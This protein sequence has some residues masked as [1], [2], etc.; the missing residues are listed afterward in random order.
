MRSKVAPALRSCAQLGERVGVAS[1]ARGIAGERGIAREVAARRAPA[2]RPSCRSTATLARAAGERREREAAGVAE[3]VEHAPARAHASRTSRAVVALVEIEAGLL[4]AEHVD[5]IGEPVLEDRRRRAAACRATTPAARR[6]A[7]RACALRRPSAR[8]T[9]RHAGS[10]DER[11]DDRRAMRSAPADRSCTHD[12]VAVAVG[13]DAGQAVGFA[14]DQPAAVCVGVEHRRARAPRRAATR[15]AKNAASI[16]LAGSNVHTRARICDVGRIRGARERM[17]RRRR[18]RRRSR[19]AQARRRRARSR[20][21]RSTGGAAHAATCSRPGLEDDRGGAAAG[22]AC[23]QPSGDAEQAADA[24]VTAPASAPSAS[25]RTPDR[26][27]LRP[28]NSDSIA[29]T[30]NSA[31]AVTPIATASAR[32]RRANTNGASGSSAPAANDRNELAAAPTG[33]PSSSGLRP[34]SSRA[35]VSSACSGSAT[36]CLA[37]LRRPRAAASPSPR[38]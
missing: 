23:G 18:A 3:R 10:A 38:R 16:A 12:D 22:C 33:E 15:R 17:R 4:A 1:I 34:S 28:V 29:P 9:Q 21:R 19:P 20:R 13:D 6:Q 27:A 37:S 36:I 32:C 24:E 11:V 35:S 7:L 14:M 2:R 26:H 8:T 5:A 25:M 30:P 31:T